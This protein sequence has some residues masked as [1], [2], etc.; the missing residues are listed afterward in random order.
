MG[1]DGARGMKDLHDVG[2]FTV[3]QNEETCTVYGMP[4][5]TAQMGA[6]DREVSLDRIAPLIVGLWQDSRNRGGR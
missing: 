4:K 5:V 3:G 1:D 2:A 6:V